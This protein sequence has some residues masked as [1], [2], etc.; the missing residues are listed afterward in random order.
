MAR[1]DVLL[2]Q[3]LA[4]AFVHEMEVDLVR[5]LAGRVDL[6]GDRHQTEGQRG[7][8]DGARRHAPRAASCVPAAPPCDRR[9]TESDRARPLAGNAA[10]GERSRTADSTAT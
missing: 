3:P 9:S 2:V 1:T 5:S 4:A 10:D 6:D 8:I 7:G